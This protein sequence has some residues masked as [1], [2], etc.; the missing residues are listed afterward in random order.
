[1]IRFFGLILL[2]GCRSIPAASERD[3]LPS[4]SRQVGAIQLGALMGLPGVY[5]LTAIATSPG[6]DRSS[7][8][9]ELTLVPADTLQR[10][11][12]RRIGGYVRSGNRLLVGALK[13]RSSEGQLFADNVVVQ[14]NPS[15]TQ[16]ISGYCE[17]CNDASVVYYTIL[18]V[19]RDRF[20]GRWVDPQTG[21]GIIVDQNGQ[22]IPN[23]AGYFCAVR[24]K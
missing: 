4:K 5:G 11:Y 18:H 12:E 1:M 17:L 9:S 21:I 22:P 7:V 23:P 13:H 2:I 3:C 6:M 24:I 14:Q 8:T 16:L 15:D 10:Y 19:G 20:S